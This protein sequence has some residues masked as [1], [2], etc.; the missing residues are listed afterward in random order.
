MGRLQTLSWIVA[1]SIVAGCN[2][3]PATTNPSRSEQITTSATVAP[4]TVASSTNAHNTAP[5]AP[6]VL[7][8][9]VTGRSLSKTPPTRVDASGGKSDGKIDLKA[10]KVTWVDFFASWCG[11][12]KEE[13]PRIES[14]AARLAKDG[15]DVQLVHVSLDDDLRQLQA[16][17][18]TTPT[19]KSSLWL[20]DGPAREGFLASLK[21]KPAPTLP[22]HALVAQ[23]GSVKC[24]VEGAFV[25]SDY[26][27]LTSVLR[28]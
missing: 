7:C 1:G 21:M 3:P 2:D 28:K 19:M 27:E 23:D 26:A 6:R 12:C 24:F 9:P 8:S 17:F 22:E 5:T 13:L 15:I 10:A 4:S 18:A 16:F 11:P 25:D 20:S 14:F